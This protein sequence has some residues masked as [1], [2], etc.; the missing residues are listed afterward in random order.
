MAHRVVFGRHTTDCPDC[1][2]TASVQVKVKAG[3]TKH[4][5]GGPSFGRLTSG[6]PRCDELANGAAPVKWSIST[7]PTAQ[8]LDAERVHHR[9]RCT[10]CQTGRGVCTYGEW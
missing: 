2:G 1:T 7:R 6:C 8:Q 4:T 9:T 5:C 10:M 3:T